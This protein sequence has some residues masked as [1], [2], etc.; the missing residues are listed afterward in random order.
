MLF[1]RRLLGLDLPSFVVAVVATVLVFIGTIVYGTRSDH[2]ELPYFVKTILPGGRCQCETSTTFECDTCLDCAASPPAPPNW[3]EDVQ[4]NWTFQFG[5]DG[6]NEALTPDQCS[7]SFPGLF[8]DVYRAA[9][10]RRANHITKE[11]LS[12]FEFVNG[13]VR[14][15]IHDGELYVLQS[16]MSDHNYRKKAIAALYAIHRAITSVPHRNSIPN[17]EFVFT[18]EDM[19]RDPAK[20]LWALARR[21]QDQNLWLMPDFGFWSWDVRALGPYT[22]VVSEVIRRESFEPWENKQKKLVWRGKLA[23]APKLRRALVDATKGKSWSAVSAIQWHDPHSMQVDFV[24]P[25]DQCNYL[26]IAHAEGNY[27]PLILLQHSGGIFVLI[28]PGRSY[29]GS[30]KYRQICRSVIISHKLQ[31]IQHYH[32][33]LISNGTN[34]NFVEVERDFSD[35]DVTMEHLLANPEDAKRIADNNVKTFR[36]RYLTAAAEACYWRA[37]IRAYAEVS[38]EPELY[39]LNDAVGVKGHHSWPD[40]RG[41]RFETFV[42]V[43]IVMKRIRSE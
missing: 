8:E 25:V 41:V 15:V 20:P 28:S 24:G 9:K 1:R 4:K 3:S 6:L 37:L 7:A 40:R 22:E 19:A 14:V 26:F 13:M 42:Y 18:V 23:Y 30:M 17:I 31:W 29:S 5:R 2:S 43:A 21:A 38:F 12:S 11:E 39:E 10:H 33:L 27:Q 16:S 34:Q 35:L 32:Y 36:E